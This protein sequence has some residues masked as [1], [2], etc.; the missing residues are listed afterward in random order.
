MDS[1]F[2]LVRHIL[3]FMNCLITPCMLCGKVCVYVHVCR[4]MLACMYARI[5]IRKMLDCLS[6]I[7][8]DLFCFQTRKETIYY[9]DIALMWAVRTGV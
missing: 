3:F 8:E 5:R 6:N 1:F 4:N 2:F 9:K 7:T